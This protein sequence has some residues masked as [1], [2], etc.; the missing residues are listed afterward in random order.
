MVASGCTLEA[1]PADPATGGTPDGAG[2]SGVPGHAGAGA[3]SSG[4]SGGSAASSAGID[5]CVSAPC[6]NG[7]CLDRVD[8][9]E[10]DCGTTGYTGEHCET[11][12]HNCAETP[13]D[14]GGV[15]T[16]GDLS[17]TCDCTGTGAMGASCEIDVDECA[18]DPC[19]HGT[20]LNGKNEYSC[21][22]TGTGFTG[23]DCG[24][25]VNEC[26]DDPCDPLTDCTNSPGGFTCSSC[27]PG[28][29]GSGRAGCEDIDECATDHGGCDPLIECANTVGSHSCGSCPVGYSRSGNSCLDIDECQNDPCLNG[30]TCDNK[31]GG[32]SCEC[33]A[34]WTGTLCGYAT[35]VVDASARGHYTNHPSYPPNGSAFAGFCASCSDV[36]FRTF[37]VFP[38]PNFT[39]TVSSVAFVAEHTFYDSIDSTETFGVYEVTSDLAALAAFSAEPAPVYDDL[40]DGTWFGSF[41]LSSSTVGTLRTVMLS[42]GAIEKA[43]YARG[44][45]LGI[46][47]TLTSASGQTAAEEWSKFSLG[48]EP[49]TE[50]LRISVVP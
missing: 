46:G 50:Q 31:P 48:N 39:G 11:L 23:N 45:G 5:D 19:V 35:L 13:C 26:D 12:I 27:P 4:G 40:G 3:T 49:R 38:V 2:A 29:K 10:C 36:S 42:S 17:R 21:D 47:I 18:D 43:S 15:C 16:D 22:C 24:T 30:G 28:Y 14:N 20:C 7:T 1:P 33:V 41:T 37:Y 34:P 25:D 8:A 6:E 44:V 9:Y 32:F